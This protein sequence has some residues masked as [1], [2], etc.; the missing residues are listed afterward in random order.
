MK[1]SVLYWRRDLNPHGYYYPLDFKSNV[2]TNSTTSANILWSERRDLNPRPSPWQGD[3]LPL[4][5]FRIILKNM[6]QKCGCK[7]KINFQIWNLIWENRNSKSSS[8]NSWYFNFTFW[9]N[10]YIFNFIR[11]RIFSIVCFLR[12]PINC[13][14][15]F[16][17]LI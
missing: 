16:F 13:S 7:F 4:S 9:C 6:H 15:I 3:A 14:C 8:R 17:V 1:S 10:S 11:L 2:S 12:I 5:Y